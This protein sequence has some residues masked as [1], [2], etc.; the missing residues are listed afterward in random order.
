VKSYFDSAAVEYGQ[1]SEKGA[2]AWL[3]NAEYEAVA[4]QLGSIE[5]LVTLDAGCGAGW[6]A[7]RLASHKPKTY[8]A[9][10]TLFSMVAKARA[11]GM[12]S[13]VADSLFLPFKPVFDVV[14]CAGALEFMD[15]PP[16][17]FHEAARVLKPGGQVTLLAPSKNIPGKIYRW[18]HRRHGFEIHLFSEDDLASQAIASGLRLESARKAGI[19]NLAARMRKPA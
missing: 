16:L 10:D 1:K 7:K 9:L 3:K 11:E 8:V 17:F 14:L 5:G 19:F 18:W 15:A 13:L 6:Y 4:A 2:W 12:D